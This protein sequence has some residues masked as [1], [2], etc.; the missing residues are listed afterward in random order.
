MT[1]TNVNSLASELYLSQAAAP[2]QPASTAGSP[3]GVAV[4]VDQVD[5]T[6]NSDA[7]H[8][9]ISET[10]RIALNAAAGTLTSAQATQLYQQVASIQAQI[11]ADTQANGGTLTPQDA[12]SISQLQSQLS[13]TIYSDAHNGAAPPPNPTITVA[14]QR[15]ALQAGRIELN[16][17]TGKLTTTQA[18]QLTQQQAQIDQQIAADKQANGG[19]LT[20]AQ[21]QQINQVQDQASQQ[22]YQMVHGTTPTGQ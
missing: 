15:E 21:A 19:T 1:I 2:K 11:T 18:Q 6:H 13:A 14:G 16:L 7:M 20:Q 3:T 5:I 22:I 9:Q 4:P 17:Q 10:G 8:R 12:D